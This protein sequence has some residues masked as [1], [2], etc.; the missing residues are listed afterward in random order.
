MKQ[1]GKSW[2]QADG[3]EVQANRVTELE[4][5]SEILGQRVAAAA[6]DIDE[7]LAA[8]SKLLSETAEELYKRYKATAPADVNSFLAYTFDKGYRFDFS[9]KDLT[10]RVW[11]AT[12]ENPSTKDYV[13]L[14]VTFKIKGESHHHAPYFGSAGDREIPEKL[15][16]LAEAVLQAEKT[17]MITAEETTLYSKRGNGG[18]GIMDQLQ[19][20]ED[21]GQLNFGQDGLPARVEPLPEVS[22]PQ[23]SAGSN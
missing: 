1:K 11:K 5:Y 18:N 22:S 14:A 10:V 7:R 19:P 20:N 4:K 21:K 17:E 3:K 15:P 13:Q 16:S 2:Y 8:I 9:R 23:E 12:K 6:E